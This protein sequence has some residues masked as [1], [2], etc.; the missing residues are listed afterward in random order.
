METLEKNF[1]KLRGLLKEKD[2]DWLHICIG[3]E[4]S[5]KS[6]LAMHLCR[7]VDPTFNVDR[8]VF[9][10]EDF[11]K[12][13]IKS[14]P[15]QAILVDEGALAFFSRDA[16]KSDVRESIKL[17]TFCRQ[18]NLF[19]CICSPSFFIIDQYIRQHRV[20]S[21]SRILK[22]GRFAL[23]NY[24][25]IKKI[26]RDKFTGKI[27]YPKPNLKDS[28]P[29]FG[30]MELWNAYLEKKKN[31]LYDPKQHEDRMISTIE[32]GKIIGVSSETIRRYI[33]D[34]RLPATKIGTHNRISEKVLRK[35]F[36][37]GS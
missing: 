33:I 28:F 9:S 1:I 25:K 10:A 30:D 23:Y 37:G 21:V 2:L 20:K 14:K 6:S 31:V 4:G 11:K 27:Y 32:A 7:M 12:A 29:K 35:L 36:C 13:V 17:L 34:K 24:K 15:N 8:I 19:I 16:M 26:Y 5:G 22:R 18:Y 3:Y